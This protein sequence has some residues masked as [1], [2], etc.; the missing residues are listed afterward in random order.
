MLLN[1]AVF[2]RMSLNATRSVFSGLNGPC[3]E[4]TKDISVAQYKAHPMRS[5]MEMGHRHQVR[6]HF[7]LATL[8]RL[9]YMFY[10]EYES[11]N[12]DIWMLQCHTSLLKTA[13][14]KKFGKSHRPSGFNMSEHV[15]M[16]VS[17]DKSLVVYIPE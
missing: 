13:T 10:W 3:L 2:R 8:N 15:I 14:I 1:D 6:N 4:Q 9:L 12:I 16:V 7:K 11:C 17:Y 5:W